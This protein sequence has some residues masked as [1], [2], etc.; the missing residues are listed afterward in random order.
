MGS[1]QNDFLYQH[2]NR[3]HLPI[4]VPDI[5]IVANDLSQPRLSAPGSRHIA[6]QICWHCSCV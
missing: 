3:D 4:L 2:V 1:A 5:L 6:G